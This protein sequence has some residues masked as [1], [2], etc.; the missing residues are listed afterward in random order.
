VDGTDLAACI[1]V[2][3]NAVQR[4]RAGHGPQM[5]VGSLLRLSGHGEHD[6]ASY[7]AP[8][9]KKQGRDCMLLAEQAIRTEGWM[10]DSELQGLREQVRDEVEKNIAQTSREPAPDP[11]REAWRALSSPELAEGW[12]VH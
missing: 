5:I 9:T 6:D 12:E 3:H 10:T 8:A 1:S 7:I 2:F 11:F 4:A